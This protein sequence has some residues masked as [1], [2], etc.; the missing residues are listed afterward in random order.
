MFK[1]ILIIIITYI[2]LA[3]NIETLILIKVYKHLKFLILINKLIK[4]SIDEL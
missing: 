2:R 3:E 1:A 4:A